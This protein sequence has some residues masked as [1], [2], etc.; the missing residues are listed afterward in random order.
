MKKL[1]CEWCGAPGKII[2][3]RYGPIKVVHCTK[4][5]HEWDVVEGEKEE[6]NDSVRSI[7]LETGVRVES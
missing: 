4:C 6:D 7:L 2:G 3:N 1:T 5:H